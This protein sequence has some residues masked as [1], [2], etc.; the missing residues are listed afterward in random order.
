[1]FEAGG[2]GSSCVLELNVDS[3]DWPLMLLAGLDADFT[4]E[5]PVE[6]AELVRRTADRLA[7]AGP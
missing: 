3:L 4:V 2:A 6:L 5:Q 1:M 7:R